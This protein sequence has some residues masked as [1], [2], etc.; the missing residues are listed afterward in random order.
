MSNS[1][2]KTLRT[3]K[4]RTKGTQQAIIRKRKI[5]LAAI[6][7]IVVIAVAIIIC[8][9]TG[10]FEKKAT[11]STLT[12]KDKGT[13]V[14]EEVSKLD[15][16]YYDEG[17]LKDY[18]K[19]T[20]K[21]YTS[22]AGSSTVKLKKLSVKDDVAYLKTIYKSAEDY[23]AFTGYEL[24][25]GTIVEAQAAG[26]DFADSFVAVKDG[27]KAKTA[28]AEDVIAKDDYKVLVIKQN[29]TVKVDGTICYVSDNCTTVNGTDSVTI[30]QADGNNDA[31]VLTYII[32]K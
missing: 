18:V 11:T 5:L 16:K 17:E 14:S 15:Q 20:I 22:K 4:T 25:Q 7:A 13:I 1:G 21:D 23:T 27:K 31:T 24:F 30:A 19:S 29:V 28:K 10:V 32:Y 26:Y 3:K 8:V 2:Q 9:V 12:L 6:I